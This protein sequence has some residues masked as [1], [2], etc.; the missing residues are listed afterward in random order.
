MLFALLFLHALYIGVTSALILCYAKLDPAVTVLALSR[1]YL[2]GYKVRRQYPVNLAAVPKLT[3][4]MLV[5]IEDG[6][7]WTHNGIDFE[8]VKRAAEINRNNGKILYGGSTLTMQVART[9]FLVPER[10]YLRKYLEV[11]VALELE[12]FLPKER[13]LELYL[14]WAEWG[15]G[16]FGIDAASRRYYGKSASKLGLEESAR[17]MALLSSPI[18]YNPENLFRS[19][20][21]RARYEYLMGKYGS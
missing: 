20:L 11:I 16:T 15:K 21:L 13:I 18:K 10:N 7:F 1:K 12:L 9:L 5:S 3:R 4:R 14:S 19:N 17:L 8:A 2:D 6:N